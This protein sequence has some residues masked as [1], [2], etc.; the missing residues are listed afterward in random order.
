MNETLSLSDSNVLSNAL[1]TLLLFVE[2][3]GLV[4]HNNNVSLKRASRSPV[5]TPKKTDRQGEKWKNK[6][7]LLFFSS[8][9]LP[10][11]IYRRGS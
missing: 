8:A 5:Y 7:T 6:S 10:E 1:R 11:Y 9:S 4:T 3:P 2:V